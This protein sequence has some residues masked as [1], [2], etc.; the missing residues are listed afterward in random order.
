MTSLRS[1]G[2]MVLMEKTKKI[3]PIG[4]GVQDYFD[5]KDNIIWKCSH[6]R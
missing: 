6:K 4:A 5:I 2:K 3:I 1:G